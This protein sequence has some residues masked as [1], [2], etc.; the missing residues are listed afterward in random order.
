MGRSPRRENCWILL[1]ADNSILFFVNVYMKAESFG[2]VSR[3]LASSGTLF[4]HIDTSFFSC[5]QNKIILKLRE[6][7]APRCLF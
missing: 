7:A 3:D 5:H 2:F 1:Y 4:S 6:M